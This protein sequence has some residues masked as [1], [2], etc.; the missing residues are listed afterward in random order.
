M[1]GKISK[2]LSCLSPAGDNSLDCVALTQKIRNEIFPYISKVTVCDTPATN[3]NGLTQYAYGEEIESVRRRRVSVAR[4]F[5]LTLSY[6]PFDR[7]F[8]IALAKE[9]EGTHK[10]PGQCAEMASIAA[11]KLKDIAAQTGLYVYTLQ[12]PD[13]NHTMVLLSETLYRSREWVNWVKEISQNSIVVDL[14]E[15]VLSQSNPN[16][17]VSPAGRNSYTKIRPR[18][19]VQCKIWDA[20]SSRHSV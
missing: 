3:H 9:V 16:A 19:L 18:A 4:L 20:F 5:D 11:V 14:W 10:M 17:L 7:K 12:L 2:G 1:L 6:A 8:V 15:G 13:Y